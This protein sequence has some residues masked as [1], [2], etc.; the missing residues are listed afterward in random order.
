MDPE[1]QNGTAAR[2]RLDPNFLQSLQ[3]FGVGEGIRTLDPNLG[4]RGIELSLQSMRV[5]GT[6]RGY[7][8]LHVPGV[9]GRR[10]PS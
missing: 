6:T 7:P 5:N 1:A 9:E 4:K 3:K 8:E 10:A 2:R